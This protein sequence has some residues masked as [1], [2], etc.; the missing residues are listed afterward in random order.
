ML[1]YTITVYNNG[2]VPAT[3]VRLVDVVPND[4]TYVAD[5]VTLN[6]L[7]VGQ[8]DG[9]TFPLIAGIPVSSADLTPPLPG[10]GE[11]VLSPGASAVVEFL[12]RVDDLT[13]AGTQIINQATVYS[14]E[15]PN[16]LTDGDGNPATG[17]EPTVVV[18]GD[19][20]VLSI[21][22]QVS[23]VGGGA[24]LAGATLEYVV[25]VRNVSSVPAQYVTITD[26]LDE[27]NPGYLAYVDLSATLNGLPDGVVYDP[28]TTTITADYFTEYGPLAPDATA[29]LRFQAVIDPNLV[30]GHHHRQHG[31]GLLG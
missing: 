27:V 12:M 6:G 16:L 18:V 29:V 4:V 7:P 23:V 14:T 30:E 26:N 24:A 22:K 2:A 9:G 21:L 25:T 5:T 15:R 10:A 13:P 8:P 19:A 17:P 28:A 3:D 31:A 20:Q 11:G 1:R